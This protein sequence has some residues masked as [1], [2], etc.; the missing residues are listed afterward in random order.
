MQTESTLD[1][2]AVERTAKLSLV[3]VVDFDALADAHPDGSIPVEALQNAGDF[4]VVIDPNGRDA[5]QLRISVENAAA[6]S[7]FLDG[8]EACA[9]LKARPPKTA[10]EK[11]AAKKKR[12]AAKKKKAAAAK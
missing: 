5:K 6:G 10:A 7:S 1:T 3:R 2:R 12:E 11:A 4:V 8:F 9:K